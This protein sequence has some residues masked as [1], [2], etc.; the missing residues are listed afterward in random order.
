[1]TSPRAEKWMVATSHPLAVDAALEMMEEG[2]NAVDAAVVAAAVLTV[3]DA[4]STGLGGDAFAMYWP[5]G[6]DSPQGFASS[7]PAPA[8][9]SVEALRDAGFGEMPEDGPWTITVPGVVA[10]WQTLLERFGTV[11]LSRG[12]APAIAIAEQG[13]PVSR[14]VA[15][16]WTD[17][18]EKLNRYPYSA[19][20]YLPGGSAPNAG[21][22]LTN[23]D[24]AAALRAVAKEG[25]QVFY[26]GWIAERI[27][28]AVREA[29]GVLRA[30]DLSEWAGPRWVNPISA[31]YRDVRVFELPPPNQGLLALQALK[32]YEGIT[33][34]SVVDEE[35]A[36]IESLKLAFADAETYIADPDV[37]P[38]PVEGL[39]SDAYL[40]MRRALVD[41]PVAAIPDAGQPGDTVYVAVVKGDEGCSFIQSIYAGFGSGVGVEGTGIVLQ[42]RG[43]GFVLE[44][45]H[46]NRPEPRKRP[47]HTIIPAMLGREDGLWGCI[48]HVGGFMQPQG[49]LQ[50][51]RNLLDRGV[52]PQT[53]VSLPRFRVLGGLRVAFEPEFDSNVVEELQNRGHQPTELSSFEAGGGQLVL[54][55][56]EGLVGGSDPRKD[57]LAGGK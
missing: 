49:R 46:R 25:P 56:K 13:F 44:D 10:G 26:D 53:A 15:A 51:L 43:A 42:N 20:V 57:G 22:R 45:G 36:A 48:G 27:E 33:T 54:R 14:T 8:A 5:K 17:S 24:L 18:V 41:K 9:L 4:R 55:S 2:G 3:V 34:T 1:M 11:N 35:H 31:T 30:S 12:L 16:D 6:T 38:V 37:Y 28:A 40:A 29:G 32:L 39:L 19:S 52:D 47:Y 7:G 21:D 23:P 50:V